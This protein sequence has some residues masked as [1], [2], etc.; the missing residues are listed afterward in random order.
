MKKFL[1]MILIANL[2]FSHDYWL[3]PKKFHLSKG[4]TLVVHLY[5]GDK[6][7]KEIERE[8]QKNMT[9]KF[10][11]ITDSSLFNLVDEIK[12]KSIPVL[13][14]KINFEGLAL[15]SMER[16]YAYIELKPKEFSEYLKHEG[17]EDVQKLMEKLPPRKVERE[18]YRRFIKSLIMIGD[19]PVGNVY[20]K[21]LG[22]KL[23]II[24]LDN[25]FKTKPGDEI[26]AQ[27]LF[28]GKPLADKTITAYN[29]EPES[30][31]INEY[32]AKTDKSGRVKF[33]IE[34]PGLWLIR[35]VHLLKCNGCE[36]ADWESFWA[37][38]SFEIKP[39]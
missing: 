16:D 1:W 34:N 14:K 9:L 11:L 23:E 27:V 36:N 4:E 39:K 17:L 6:L 25:P 29:L 13:V 12:D 24:L 5:V 30:K 37:S 33:K 3:Q 20:G 32:K 8:F 35:L 7:E 2:A 10:E 22:Q 31:K 15:L 38:Y 21:I 28:D 18:R 19:K 26:T